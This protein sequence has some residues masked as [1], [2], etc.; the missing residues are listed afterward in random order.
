MY[1]PLTSLAKTVIMTGEIAETPNPYP[2]R[3]TSHTLHFM[4]PQ[5]SCE[6][7]YLKQIVDAENGTARL[8]RGI[9]NYTIGGQTDRIRLWGIKQLWFGVDAPIM[10]TNGE[11]SIEQN[12]VVGAL[13]C[14]GPRSCPFLAIENTNSTC[15]E[16]QV[17]FTATFFWVNG[18]RRVV[19][20]KTKLEPQPLAVG[21]VYLWRNGTTSFTAKVGRYD[22]PQMHIS[23]QSWV[24]QIRTT[25][26]YWTSFMILDTFVRVLY[27]T[28]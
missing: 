19:V 6:T 1:S 18:N 20:E 3:N 8:T 14:K 9:Y 11:F 5:I 12:K 23:S 2:E 15:R 22:L 13:G 10:E 7:R 21:E 25:I 27:S 28:E 26:P 17:M 16:Q 4:G 24:S